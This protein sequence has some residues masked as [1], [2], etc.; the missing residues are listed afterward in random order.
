MGYYTRF[1]GS[2]SSKDTFALDAFKRDAANDETFGQYDM[3][4]DCFITGDFFG[5]DTAK[6]YDWKNDLE[7]LS[8][9]YPTLLFSLNGEGEESGDI[10][11]AYARNGKVI[12]V[13]AEVVFNIP[14]LDEALPYDKSASDA[15]RQKRA[16]EI[17]SE[18]N[19]LQEELDRVV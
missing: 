6:W 9:E 11:K 13:R 10:W 14:D 4:K 2:V 5:G 12:T 17:R 7:A 3:P 8:K 19:R 16:D 1:E 15:L 18:I